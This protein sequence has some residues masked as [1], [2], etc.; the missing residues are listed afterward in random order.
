MVS[1][2]FSSFSGMRATDKGLNVLDSILPELLSSLDRHQDSGLESRVTYRYRYSAE[3]YCN[4]WI[5]L[6]FSVVSCRL[7]AG[8]RG[9]QR[10]DING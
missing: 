9:N 10:F 6:V 5:V 3:S 1:I 2:M 8:A 4:S 7:A